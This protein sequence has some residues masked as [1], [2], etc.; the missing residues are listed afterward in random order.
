MYEFWYNYVKSK[1]EEKAKL[2]YIDT[3]G[4]IICIKTEGIYSDIAE[5]VETRF[6]TSNYTDCYQKKK[7]NKAPA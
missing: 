1:Y 7:R 5:D 6:G 3:E 2:C 4:L